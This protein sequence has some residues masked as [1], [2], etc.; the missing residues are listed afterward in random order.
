MPA[1]PEGSL[2]AITM[3]T[4]GVLSESDLS[5]GY[6]VFAQGMGEY[7]NHFRAAIL[8][9]GSRSVLAGIWLAIVGSKGFS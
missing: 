8:E 3:T 9:T 4:G 7:A 2:P 1:P 6:S 5:I